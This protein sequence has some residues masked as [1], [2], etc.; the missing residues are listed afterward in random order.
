MRRVLYFMLISAVGWTAA[1]I[2]EER[3]SPAVVEIIEMPDQPLEALDPSH[4]KGGGAIPALPLAIQT[5][6]DIQY[7]TGGIGEEEMAQL[8][9]VARDY[10]L[11]VLLSAKTGE[12]VAGVMLRVLNAD[13]KEVLSVSS[14]GPY[15]YAALPSGAYTVEA[16]RDGEMRR[17]RVTVSNKG[18]AKPHLAF[19]QP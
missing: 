14:A 16:V 19:T 8:K 7:I 15:V 5:D 18:A 11:Q 12:Y 2:A 10:N 9:A 1:A 4:A 3:L 13:G 17:M 6:G